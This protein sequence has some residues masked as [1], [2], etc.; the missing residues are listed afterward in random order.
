MCETIYKV[1]HSSMQGF[2][3]LK[4]DRSGSTKNFH[5]HLLKV[6]KLV[7]PKS[8]K[9]ISKAQTDIA[10]KTLR[11][12]IVYL[13]ADAD[14][15]LS[16][17]ERKS[18]QDLVRL[19]NEQASPLVSQLSRQ[20][21]SNHLSRVYIQ[22]QEKLKIEFLA[23]QDHLS[24]TQDAWNTPNVTAFMGVT[25][26]FINKDFKMH[27]LTVSIPHVQG[28]FHLIFFFFFLYSQQLI[29]KC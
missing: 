18:F 5:E 20:N 21:I 17:V 25:G 27:G 28:N 9:K 26:H 13:I 10:K 22:T 15:P 12:V 19:L 8:N 2:S 24:F 16:V 11:T 1:L 4:K 7:D 23:K 29:E 14:L 6:L 3:V